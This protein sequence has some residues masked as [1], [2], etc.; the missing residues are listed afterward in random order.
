[1]QIGDRIRM[2]HDFEVE[3]FFDEGWHLQKD[4][5]GTLRYIL[6]ESDEL[7]V[8]FNLAFRNGGSQGD[9]LLIVPRD[10]VVIA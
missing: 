6:E 2:K 5:T 7:V 10:A 1:M 8:D 3:P 9:I 4:M